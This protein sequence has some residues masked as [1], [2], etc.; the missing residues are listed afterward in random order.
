MLGVMATSTSQTQLTW[1]GPL[2]EKRFVLA[3]LILR[4][5]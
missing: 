3:V 4:V 1:S 2:D 5:K